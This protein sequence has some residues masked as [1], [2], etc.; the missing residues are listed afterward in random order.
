MGFAFLRGDGSKLSKFTIQCGFGAND[1][2]VD[3]GVEKEGKVEA[4]VYPQTHTCFNTINIPFYP[5]YPGGG[6]GR[7]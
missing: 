4:K 1:A 6:I 5:N 7:H 2:V 3:D